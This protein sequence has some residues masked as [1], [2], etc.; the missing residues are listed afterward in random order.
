[1]KVFSCKQH[2][3]WNFN[4]SDHLMSFPCKH[5]SSNGV[6]S[7]L[8][9][10]NNSLLD[11]AP[12]S[13]LSEG[14]GWAAATSPSTN[15]PLGPET[16]TAGEKSSGSYSI[17]ATWFLLLVLWVLALLSASRKWPSDGVLLLTFTESLVSLEQKENNQGLV[18]RFFLFLEVSVVLLRVD[19]PERSRMPETPMRLPSV[20]P[21]SWKKNSVGWNHS[22]KKITK[23]RSQFTW[24][25]KNS[26][27]NT[28]RRG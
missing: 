15:S 20:M 26:N 16:G 19:L 25:T 4:I 24:K 13:P 6:P 3:I 14:L 7:P 8:P 17:G 12:P 28:Q 10:S 27:T 1:M 9:Y 2:G 22:M 23:I 11:L 18:L 5:E 21:L